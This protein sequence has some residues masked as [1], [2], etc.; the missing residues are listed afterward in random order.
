MRWTIV[1]FNHPDKSKSV[2]YLQN[3]TEDELIECVKDA[4]RNGANLMSIRGFQVNKKV[5]S[6]WGS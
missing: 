2:L 4:I 1:A 5:E 3:V 6:K